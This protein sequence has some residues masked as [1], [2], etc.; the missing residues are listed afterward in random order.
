MLT[1]CTMGRG[2]LMFEDV[3]DVAEGVYP[4]SHH[5]IPYTDIIIKLLE[6]DGFQLVDGRPEV[7]DRHNALKTLLPS[8]R[9]ICDFDA[10]FMKAVLPNW[11]LPES[12]V[13]VLIISNVNYQKGKSNF[14]LKLKRVIG[15]LEM[16]QAKQQQLDNEEEVDDDNVVLPCKMPVSISRILDAY[17]A[18]YKPAALV[19]MMPALGT[20]ATRV[21]SP[22][23]DDV[24]HSMTFFS[25]ITSPQAGGKSGVKRLVDMLLSKVK[26]Y[27][28]IEMEKQRKYEEERGKAKN[29]EHQPEDPHACIRCIPEK[30][31][32]TS[33]SMLLD[34]AR[35]Q[36]LIQVTPE[37]DS[38]AKCNKNTWSSMDDILRKA[39][40]NDAI[41]QYY[42]SDN[43]HKSNAAAFI[44]VMMT[45]TPSAMYN[46]LNNVEGGLVSRFCFATLPDSYGRVVEAMGNFSDETR[47]LIMRDV[48]LLMREG[49]SEE[50]A[51][52]FKLK[53]IPIMRKNYSIIDINYYGLNYAYYAH[54][55][56]FYIAKVADVVVVVVVA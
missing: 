21:R 53:Q 7:G 36:H 1:L 38:M 27:D 16:E 28:T 35:G 42:M 31:S 12:E 23:I 22:Y 34:N 37:I 50:Y 30:T 52:A 17:P 55:L 41:G 2:L 8:L 43:S 15:V 13:Q 54:L 44:N 19:A 39:Y 24:L 11:G 5:G 56:Q 25:C 45:G 26:D 14:P 18:E 33:L 9:H 6:N 29:S 32:N 4:T 20:L 51:K 47:E 49:E 3:A 48:E 10:A 46:Y 40:D